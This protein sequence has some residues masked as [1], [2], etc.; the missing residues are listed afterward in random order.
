MRCAPLGTRQST[1]N[2][3][4]GRQEAL[5]ASAILCE[6]FCCPKSGLLNSIKGA[7]RGQR[8]APIPSFRHG[9]FFPCKPVE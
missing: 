3:C 8:K 6:T 9:S 2:S 5:C 7:S 1:A 4:Q